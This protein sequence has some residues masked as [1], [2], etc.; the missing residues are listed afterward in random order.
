ML[1]F[2]VN[3]FKIKSCY[4]ENEKGEENIQGKG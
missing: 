1:F 4:F 2:E 3:F